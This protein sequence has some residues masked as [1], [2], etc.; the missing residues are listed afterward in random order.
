MY[1]R[2]VRGSSTLD[3][4]L[5]VGLL[6]GLMGE[7]EAP[8]SATKGGSFM[9]RSR[10]STGPAPPEVEGGAATTQLTPTEKGE[11]GW[12]VSAKVGMGQ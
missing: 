1:G 9:G 6:I 8:L 2:E 4:L 10:G 3:R 11:R 5:G 12:W 7:R